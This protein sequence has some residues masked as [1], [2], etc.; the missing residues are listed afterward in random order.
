MLKRVRESQPIVAMTVIGTP[1]DI[2][3]A[4]AKA[5]TA[6]RRY[7]YTQ[8]IT[9]TLEDGTQFEAKLYGLTKPKLKDNIDRQFRH[10][11]N[12]ESFAD[13]WQDGDN[14][15]VWYTSWRMTISLCGR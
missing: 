9:Y 4:A 8:R 13:Q 6:S 12:R 1:S 3:A 14:P 2:G 5:M 11:E 7:R 15:A 10:I